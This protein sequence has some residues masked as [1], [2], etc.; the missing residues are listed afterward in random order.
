MR[1]FIQ[2]I[3]VVCALVLVTGCAH[4]RK[5][6]QAKQ[7]E[8]ATSSY[9]QA[10]RWGY[11]DAALSY[12]HPDVATPDALE[13]LARIRITSYDEVRP[14]MWINE[15][16]ATQV[17]RIEYVILD[18]QRVDSLL[19]QQEWRFDPEQGGWLLHSPLPRFE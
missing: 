6:R 15:T 7:L 14:A 16:T 9:R 12:L 3:V 11:V 8:A 10:L 19:D 2:I 17:A 4:V 5:D 13:H 1:R 18:Q